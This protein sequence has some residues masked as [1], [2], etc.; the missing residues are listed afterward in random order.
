MEARVCSSIES[1]KMSEED[2]SKLLSD[3]EILRMTA[4]RQAASQAMEDA[5]ILDQMG[6]AIEP[7]SFIAIWSK[8]HINGADESFMCCLTSVFILYWQNY[9]MVK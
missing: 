3:V 2:K 1:V 6:K 8:G 7:E 4:C 9:Q 5:A